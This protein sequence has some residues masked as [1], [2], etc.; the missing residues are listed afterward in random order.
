VPSFEVRTAC[1]H[2]AQVLSLQ[3][4]AKEKTTPRPTTA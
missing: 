4:E 1:E 2:I 3:V